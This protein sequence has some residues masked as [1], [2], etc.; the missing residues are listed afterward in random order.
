MSGLRI[1]IRPPRPRVVAAVLA[2]ALLLAVPMACSSPQAPPAAAAPAA[3]AAP[4]PAAAPNAP[5]PAAQATAS[6]AGPEI[7]GAEKTSPPAASKLKVGDTFDWT[8]EMTQVLPAPGKV[9]LDQRNGKP[10]ILVFWG[11]GSSIARDDLVAFDA[12]VAKEGLRSRADVYAVGGFS[13]A[14]GSSGDIRDM[15]IILGVKEIPVLVDPD[16]LLSIRL[17][18]EQYPD[19]DVIGS[20]G[21]V[22]AKALRGVDHGNL[23]AITGPRGE[24]T[25]LTAA[26]YLRR[27]AV[28]KTGPSIPR[29][30]PF[31]PSDRLVGG[32]YPD[33]ELPRFS[34]QG[35]GKGKTERL[36]KLLSG[37]RPA[38]VMFFSSTCDHCQVDVPQMVAFQKAHPGTIDIVGITRI[39]NANHRKVSEMYFQQQ[40]ITFPIL[41]DSGNIT[42]Q[43]QVTST[44]TEFF[45]S[46][47]GTVVKVT[48]FQHQ[49]LEADWMKLLPVLKAAPAGRPPAKPTGWSF[50]LQFRD[51][52]GK[53]VDLASMAGRPTL[54]HFWATWCMPCRAELPALVKRVPELESRGNVVFAS[55][56]TDPAALAKHRKDTGLAF[57]SLLAPSGGLAA[58]IDFGRSVPRTYVLDPG[59][60]IVAVYPGT[61]EWDNPERFERILGRLSP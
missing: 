59:G 7:A 46:P 10:L 3:S 58:K 26:D 9:R 36:S 11:V 50:P 43:W 42:D 27:V 45:L 44:P 49:T 39:R 51:E 47:G 41:E 13:A 8:T 52:A 22:L 14:K 20:D 48:Y 34:G 4:P 40:G 35:W 15:A 25:P 5:R 32:R 16:F 17:G 12:F 53:V 30:F 23:Q 1:L 19:I 60:R 37:E 29:T 2:F 21:K 57:K 18:A 54:L 55:V 56:E 38:V 28:Q 33:F 24:T 61:Y 31:Y 6:A